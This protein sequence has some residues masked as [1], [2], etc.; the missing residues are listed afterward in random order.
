M[1]QAAGRV[2]DGL[3]VHPLTSVDYLRE[4]TLPALR[5]ARGGELGDFAVCLSA[6]VVLGETEAD[7]SRAEQAVKGQIAFYASTPA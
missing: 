2:A 3:L 5:E 6:M 7:R 4:R 1:T